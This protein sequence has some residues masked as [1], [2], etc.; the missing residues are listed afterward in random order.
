MI[1]KIVFLLM[2]IGYYNEANYYLLYRDTPLTVENVKM[3]IWDLNIQYPESSYKLMLNE[4]GSCKSN[5][6]RNYHNLWGMKKPKHRVTLAISKGKSNYAKYDCWLSSI[7]DYK[8]WQGPE[9]ITGDYLKY[10]RK[11]H[12]W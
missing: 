8:I 3:A 12:W 1:L 4:S 9:R 7:L 10:L 2:S 5:L 6:A 11:R